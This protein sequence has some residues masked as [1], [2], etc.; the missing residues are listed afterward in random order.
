MKAAE[1]AAQYNLGYD[2]PYDPTFYRCEAILI[3]GPWAAP[4]NITR[5][6]GLSSTG[7][8]SPG[9]WDVSWNWN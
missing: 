3:N 9:V 4:S 7:S 8:K 2:V 1:Y 5:G 6:V